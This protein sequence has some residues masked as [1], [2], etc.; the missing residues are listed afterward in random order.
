VSTVA[1]AIGHGFRRVTTNAG[2]TAIE[3]ISVDDAPDQTA[4]ITAA[5]RNAIAAYTEKYGPLSTR[6]V[7]LINTPF[8]GIW[9]MAADGFILLGQGEFGSA[10]LW[11]PDLSDRIIDYI[12]F[13]EVAHLWAG[14]GT[15]VDHYR[16]NV[17]SEGLAD[18][19]AISRLEETYGKT[20]NL[21]DSENTSFFANLYI[22]LFKR[23]LMASFTRSD[24][25]HLNYIQNV[26][27]GFDE[28]VI[29]APEKQILNGRS[30]RDY[31]KGYLVFTTLENYVGKSTMDAGLRDYFSGNNHRLV[32]AE[33]FKAALQRHTD[34]PLTLFFDKW[35]YS[36]DP[37][38]FA[39]AGIRP[40]GS[41]TEVI[42]RKT[43]TAPSA[44]EVETIFEAG[45]NRNMIAETTENMTV[46]IPPAIQGPLRG[47]ILD[48][49]RRV[50]ETNKHNNKT[51]DNLDVYV[52]GDVPALHRRHPQENYFL[53]ISPEFFSRRH[54]IESGERTFGIRIDGSDSVTH[55]WYTSIA[56]VQGGS[57]TQYTLGGN[58]M[59]DR[60]Q[61]IKGAI[62][63]DSRRTLDY[64]LGVQFPIYS[65]L[66][67]GYYGHYYYPSSTLLI[68]LARSE[69]WAYDFAAHYLIAKAS[70]INVNQGW[71]VVADTQY[72]PVVNG[73]N[74][75]EFAK[76]DIHGV[77]ALR[78]APNLILAPQTRIGVGRN[79]PRGFE[80]DLSELRGRSL[81]QLGNNLTQFSIDLAFPIVRGEQIPLFGMVQVRSIC[82]SVYY[83]VANVWNSSLYDLDPNTFH[84]IA[85]MEVGLLLTTVADTPIPLTIGY[86]VPLPPKVK[87]HEEAMYY[88]SF[89]S[90]LTLFTAVFGF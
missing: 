63:Y 76:A 18:Y 29:Q 23:G 48:P 22:R 69:N 53:G 82:G 36:V 40:S 77:W 58:W 49:D 4:R 84:P 7:T 70:H 67:I 81:N 44:L 14:V 6:R 30:I 37:I 26:R 24:V 34:R 33:D 83:D 73:W 86:A 3:V 78:L 72:A 11:A 38:D 61:L 90:P 64:M 43:G 13:H 28:P 62:V 80:F 51:I 41:A 85:G 2:T 71:A 45:R 46:L 55:T 9:G 59:L 27:A 42:I 74:Q 60:N 88:F 15:T 32:S 19:L 12:V 65:E 66:D 25:S 8:P 52:F 57:D 10:R 5:A 56:S 68:G 20:E 39:V 17:L 35:F 79:L 47:V 89:N 54:F 75:I 1:F 31:D 50:A 21:V 16:E 87:V